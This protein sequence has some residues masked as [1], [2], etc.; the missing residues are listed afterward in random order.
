VIVQRSTATFA[1]TLDRLLD[2]VRRQG[3]SVFARV[4]H[5]A[6]ARDA[7]L[8]LAS[9]EVVLVGN[10]QAG[11]PLM[12]SDPRVGIELPLR[13][14]V[15]EDDEGTLVG[16]RDPRELSQTYHLAAHEP[17]LARMAQLLEEVAGAAAG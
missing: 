12:Q 16:Y 2:A 3:L 4:D 7:G 1:D 15:W 6:A 13:L 10:P 11:T 5:A 9:E 17:I 8:E 14:L